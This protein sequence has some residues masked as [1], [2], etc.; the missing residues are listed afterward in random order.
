MIKSPCSITGILF[1]NSLVRSKCK[2][3]FLPSAHNMF[4]R[5]PV[6]GIRTLSKLI[7]VEDLK[8]SHKSINLRLGLERFDY[9]GALNV[10]ARDGDLRNGMIIHGLVL[11]SGLVRRAFL[12]NSLIDMYSKCGKVDE[13]R[14]VFDNAVELDDSSWNLLLSAYVR[15]GW[16]DVASDILVW[17]HRNGVK[18]NSA[19]LG[20]VLNASRMGFDDPKESQRLLHGCV[21]KIGLDLGFLVGS[22]MH[23]IFT[24]NGGLDEA[25]QVF[26]CLQNSN[27]VVFNAMIGGFSQ[28]GTE[29][30]RGNQVEALRLFAEVMRR[31]MRPSRLT[32]KSVLESSISIRE[33]KFGK[34]IHAHVIKNNLEEDEV[35]GSALIMLYSGSDSVEESLKCFESTPKK[36]I[37][38]WGSMIQGYIQS[39]QLER[40]MNLF[41]NFL[42]IGRK[43]DEAIISCLMVGSGNSGMVRSG[44]QIHCY[45]VKD[46]LDRCT[47]CSNSQMF[48]YSNI[49]DMDASIEIFQKTATI[50]VSS[51]CL[52][53]LSHALHGFAR[54]ALL[55]FEKME[56]FKVS[57][58]QSTFLAVLTACSNGGL[59]DEGFR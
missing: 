4:D 19:A 11:V 36:D 15:I 58:K 34:Q 14:F 57:P 50:D 9:A 21:I 20:C 39:G 23:C 38:S 8:V 53:I 32:F 7:D 3:A 40:A 52:L 37:V 43:P 28:L 31:R 47:I 35:I 16:L 26:D 33:F 45:A 44:E 2:H 13:A 56:E 29:T 5:I 6:R 10:C 59:M 25:L 51:W 18:L 54:E 41:R 30:C 17:M 27:L 48:F 46:G 49:G 22:A 55:L 12:T 1:S 42:R 24:E